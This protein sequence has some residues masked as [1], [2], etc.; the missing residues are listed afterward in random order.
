MSNQTIISAPSTCNGIDQV[1]LVV[2]IVQGF[3]LIV[4]N[5]PIIIVVLF[6]RV[7]RARKEYVVIAGLAFTDTL[8][9]IAVCMSGIARTIMLQSGTGK[10]LKFVIKAKN[11]E[12]SF[13]IGF[14]NAASLEC[15]VN[16]Y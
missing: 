9:G 15:C 10:C 14:F 7:I 8:T 1:T 11:F 12:I 2:N 4:L 13:R 3:S 6:Q 16:A 5:V